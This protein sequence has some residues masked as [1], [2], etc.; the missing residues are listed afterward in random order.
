MAL[1]L[2]GHADADGHRHAL[3]GAPVG[4]HLLLLLFG[5]EPGPQD[6]AR[7]LDGLAQ[8]VQVRETLLR[9]PAGEDHRELLAAVAVGLPAA[10][11]L[12]QLRR[13]HPEHLI[14]DVVPMPV[15]D[16][17][18]VVHVDHRHAVVPAQP[19]QSFV[20][21]APGRG[22]LCSRGA[23]SPGVGRSRIDTSATCPR[24]TASRTMPGGVRNPRSA[25]SARAA[26]LSGRRRAIAWYTT[27]SRARP[28]PLAKCSRVRSASASTSSANSRRLRW[29]RQPSSTPAPNT[30]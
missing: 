27:R 11:H 4:Q 18:E 1:A 22:R 24:M 16:A 3:A 6:E 12:S 15:V 10:R 9:V 21:G 20:E 17:L 25:V 5:A 2:L 28:W 29:N 13:D 14:A 26:K 8:L 23:V 7:V 19:Q 30:A